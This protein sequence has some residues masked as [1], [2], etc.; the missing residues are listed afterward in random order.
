MRRLPGNEDVG[1]L[2]NDIGLSGWF[3]AIGSVFMS[4]RWAA[5]EGAHSK[6]ETQS[7]ANDVKVPDGP[8]GA[9]RRSR[10]GK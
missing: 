1:V 8:E 9:R 7:G 5:G 6:M 3:M 4:Q 10:T 2:I